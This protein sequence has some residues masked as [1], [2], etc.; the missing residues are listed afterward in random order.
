MAFY[1]IPSKQISVLKNPLCGN[2]NM[3][4]MVALWF[5]MQVLDMVFTEG[6]KTDYTYCSNNLETVTIFKM[7]NNSEPNIIKKMLNIRRLLY[8]S[9]Y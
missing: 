1:F 7:F 4:K 3:L 8:F 5:S 6:D 2:D 9:K